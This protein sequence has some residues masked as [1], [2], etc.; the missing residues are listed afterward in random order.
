MYVNTI[1]K[2][3]FKDTKIRQTE[4]KKNTTEFPNVNMHF[5]QNPFHIH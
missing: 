2:Y 5:A 3:T 1:C 4:K